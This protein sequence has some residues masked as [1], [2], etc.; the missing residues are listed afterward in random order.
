MA[1]Y[2]RILA[3]VGI[4]ACLA[5][6]CRADDGATVPGPESQDLLKGVTG[7]VLYAPVREDSIVAVSLPG[8]TETIIKPFGPPDKDDRPTCHALSGPDHDGR[9]AFV[10]DHFFVK[11]KANRRHLL[12]I[13]RIDGT[14]ET[15][16][17]SRPG[18]AMWAG[19]A[20]GKGEIG[21]HLALAPTGGKVAFLSG[22]SGKQMPG[23]LFNQGT[24]EFWDIEKKERIPSDVRSIDQPMSWFPDGQRIAFVRFIARKDVPAI[25]VTI[26]QFGSGRYTGEWNELPAIY[27]LDLNSGDSRFLSL[28]WVPVVSADGLSV[29]VSGWIP[30]ATKGIEMVWKRIDVATGVASDVSW[31]G[32]A[33][34][35]LANPAN[36][37]VLYRGLP[38]AGMR[39]DPAKLAKFSKS[40]K[41]LTVKLSSLKTG[42]FQTVISEIHPNV[43]VSPVSFGVVMKK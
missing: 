39:R 25:G 33:G 31:P 11:D 27:I 40:E 5:A 24:I 7:Y 19:S 34:G 43:Q 28:G 1:C 42:A 3:V 17:F 26:E 30:S 29:F 35:L 21:K 10:E 4:S 32:D 12:K 23:A 16:L 6:A 22:L 9:F 18:D 14:D 8:L 41:P 36:D 38:T 2:A 20:A 37:L 15:V 13:R